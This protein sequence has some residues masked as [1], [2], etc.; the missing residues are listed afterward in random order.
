MTALRTRPRSSGAGPDP[1][2]R[3]R[4][5]LRVAALV[6]TAIVL[7]TLDYRGSAG[8]FGTVRDGVTE[9]LAP[10]RA[11]GGWITAPLRNGWK[12]VTDYDDVVDENAR[13]R[14]EVA[15]AQQ[16]VLLAG[17]LQRE[18]DDLRLEAGINPAPGVRRITARVVDAPVSSFERTIELDRG[19]DDGIELGMPVTTGGGLLGRI[20]QV[21]AS[22]SRVE[23]VTDPDVTVGVRLVKSGDLGTTRGEGPDRP[24][25]IDLI[26]LDTP[27][28][29]GESVV[30][31]GLRGS[32]YPEGLLV[33]TVTAARPEP[34]ADRQ[35]VEV[36]PVATAD[37]LRFATVILFEPLPLPEPITTTDPDPP[38]T[39]TPGATSVPGAPAT[40]TTPGA[41]PGPTVT[42]SADPSTATTASSVPGT[43]ATVPTGSP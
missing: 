13:L 38:A 43:I 30:T 17:E 26:S 2:R 4:R 37:D 9:A 31:S 12:G 32:S 19:G 34:I 24:I 3:R 11:V 22:R 1:D 40:T 39:T 14:D 16:D 10:V 35:V 42:P 8:V 21:S 15:R 33:G 28:L 27:V 6:A 29:P 36:R 25:V 41:E 20:A 18:L 23:L 7:L 5:R